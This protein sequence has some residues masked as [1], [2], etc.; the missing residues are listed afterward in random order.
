MENNEKTNLE[1]NLT[2]ET[3]IVDSAKV[4]DGQEKTLCDNDQ[5]SLKDEKDK[6]LSFNNV[7]EQKAQEKKAKDRRSNLIFFFTVL[8]LIL[9]ALLIR[10]LVISSYYVIGDS[11]VPTLNDGDVVWA[12][13]LGSPKRGD[14][15]IV[16]GEAS[17]KMLIKR[18]VALDGDSIVLEG[19][20]QKGYKVIVLTKDGQRISESYD[21]V[22]LP[23]LNAAT[24]GCLS[25]TPYKVEGGIFVMG[26]NR[27]VSNDSRYKGVFSPSEL[28]GVVISI[29]KSK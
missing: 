4:S 18:V 14:V 24:L 12:N 25:T 8:L 11:M 21:G 7:E 3:D 27:I 2:R 6:T 17:S 20:D 26:D 19:D 9:G 29:E 23:L 15:V 28:I 22:D 16:K 13:K 1:Q 5:L 10:T